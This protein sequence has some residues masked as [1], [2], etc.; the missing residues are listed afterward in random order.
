MDTNKIKGVYKITNI[1]DGKVYIGESNDIYKRWNIHLNDL[2]N[3]KHHSNKL[4]QDFNIYKEDDFKFEI[5][6]ILNTD[7]LTNYKIQME[8]IL[9][10]HKYIKKYNSIN[11][12]YNVENTVAEIL[13]G[14]R[15]IISSHID[16]VYIYKKLIEIKANE[17]AEIYKIQ[18]DI[19]YVYSLE[20]IKLEDY[21]Y[22]SFKLMDFLKDIGIVSFKSDNFKKAK[23]NQ[24]YQ[25]LGLFN[26]NKKEIVVSENGKCFLEDIIN[27]ENHYIEVLRKVAGFEKKQPKIKIN[28]KKVGN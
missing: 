9:L 8:L 24:C 19:E 12:G 15:V 10:E 23:I 18:D 14:N 17:I 16:K 1:N 4:Q 5:L 7:G 6:E 20:N 26:Y 22:D 13:K 28:E 25:N 27:A 2:K 21:I 3:N 11:M